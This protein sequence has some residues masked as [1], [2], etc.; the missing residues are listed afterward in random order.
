MT[1]RTTQGSPDA[2]TA[3]G[4]P[5][6]PGRW[7]DTGTPDEIGA[8]YAALMRER[9]RRVLVLQSIR[10]S[11]QEQPSVRAVTACARRWVADVFRIAEDVAKSKRESRQ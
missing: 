2:T 7:P 3:P 11:L 6:A 5:R 8:R 9:A 1:R 4:R 10:A